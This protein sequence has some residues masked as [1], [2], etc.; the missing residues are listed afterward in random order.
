MR[1]PSAKSEVYGYRLNYAPNIDYRKPG[2]YHGAELVYFFANMD[3]LNTAI[4]DEDE[5]NVKNVQADFVEFIKTGKIAK[6]ATYNATGKI[7]EYGKE[8]SQIEF[9]HKEIIKDVLSS[10]I[11]DKVRNEYINNRR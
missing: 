6:Y 8:I 5:K 1:K 10:G 4:S 3:K 7:I 11:A 2:A 9:P